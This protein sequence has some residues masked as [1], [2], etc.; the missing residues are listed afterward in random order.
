M[1]QAPVLLLTMVYV[2]IFA[3]LKPYRSFYINVLE[4]FTLVDIMLQ[5]MIASTHQ[6]KVLSNGHLLL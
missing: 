2:A 4:V 3:Y 1:L 5:L 6:L